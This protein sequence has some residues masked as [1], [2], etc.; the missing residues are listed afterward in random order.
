VFGPLIPEIGRTMA[1]SDWQLGIL[2]GSYGLA[3][4]LMAL[5]AGW[6][7]DRY[8]GASLAA[9]PV[10]FAAGVVVLAT[11]PAFPLLVLGRFLM[12]LGHTLTFVG[13]FTALVR[14]VGDAR[15]S[16]RLNVFE[17]GSM[18]GV[19]GGLA[20][21][22]ALPVEW[23]WRRS[24]LV[25]S[26]PILL[27]LA[28]APVLVRLFRGAAGRVAAGAPRAEGAPVA[29][30]TRMLV[31]VFVAG[32]LYPM[33]WTA[34]GQFLL[35]LRAT[36]EFGLDRA[37]ISRL[38]GLAQAV[39]LA[40]LLPIGRLADRFGVG[41]LGAVTLLFGLPSILVSLGPY[42]WVVAGCALY[43][44]GLTGWVLPVG[45]I[46]RLT[47]P[48]RVGARLGLYRLLG[49]GAAFLGPLVCGLLGSEGAGWLVAGCGMVGIL[50]GLALL[51]AA[52]P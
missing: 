38:Y 47:P 41:V 28:L 29:E 40:A 39:D 11:A 27:G 26:S 8:L 43:G 14:D 1:L 45:T 46:R 16:T 48:G 10:A 23:G 7:A 2:A 51:A 37:G 52:P 19:L 21:V 6:F 32:S 25:G 44:L 4:M 9:A 18:L 50:A 13:G 3:R 42:P 35:P 22:G 34:V 17:S 33:I 49:D 15:V 5:P 12:G 31:L 30:S 36:R 24:F 20:V